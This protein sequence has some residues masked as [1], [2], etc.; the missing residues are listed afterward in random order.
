[1]FNVTLRLLYS[2]GKSLRYPMVRMMSA[3]GMNGTAK[4][5]ILASA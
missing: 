3:V 1:M 5:K 4:I 2:R